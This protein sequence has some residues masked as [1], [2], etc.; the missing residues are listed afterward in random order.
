MIR[1]DNR[2]ETLP[3]SPVQCRRCDAVVLVRKA[4]WQQT[5]I[6]WNQDSARTCLE[7]KQAHDDGL[8]RETDFPT[9]SALR[10]TIA[11]AAVT[12]ELLVAQDDVAVVKDRADMAG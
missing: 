1:P 2:L 8:L 9:C 5:S 3:M 11:D 4:S 12:G 7:R 10:Q 6:Q